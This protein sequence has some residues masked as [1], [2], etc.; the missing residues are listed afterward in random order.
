[1]TASND[2]AKQKRRQLA[3][4][5]VDERWPAEAVRRAT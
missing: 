2:L 3:G 5:F 4:V 1:M